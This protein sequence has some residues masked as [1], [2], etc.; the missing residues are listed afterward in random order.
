MRLFVA[1]LVA[2]VTCEYLFG[3]S[4]AFSST[5][6]IQNRALPNHNHLNEYVL[7]RRRLL[8]FV[9][10]PSIPHQDGNRRRNS[11]APGSY[12]PQ[13][14]ALRSLP[15]PTPLEVSKNSYILT[16]IILVRALAFVYGVAFLVA[17][18]Q[19]KGLIGDN[20]ICPARTILDNAQQRGEQIRRR[21]EAWLSSDFADKPPINDEVNSPKNIWIQFK[22]VSPIRKFG[23]EL[24]R[25]SR[26]QYWRER[27]WDRQDNMGRPVTTLLW[28]AKDRSKLNRWLDG[29]AMT[30]LGLS[31]LSFVFGA[32]N[33]PLMA[34]LWICQRSLMAV[35]GPFYGYGW[36]PQLAELGFHMMFLVPL[37]SVKQISLA[38][39]PPSHLV[40]YA[41]RFYLFKIMIGA[42]LIKL[43]SRD[44]KWKW[45]HLTAMNYFYE[46]QPIPNPFTRY[47]HFNP[48]LFHKFEVL[49]NHFVELIA[50]WLLLVPICKWRRLGGFIQIAFQGILITSGNLSFL[51]WLT[52]VPAIACL[53]DA[54]LSKLF[55][56]KWQNIAVRAAAG[57]TPRNSGSSI[58]RNIVSFGFV[59]LMG[60][61][62]IP[63][64][65]NLLSQKQ[66]MNASFDPLRLANTFGAFGDV[67]EVREEFIISATSDIDKPW[68]EYRFKV[69]PGEIMRRPKF[70]SPYHYRLDWQMWIAATMKD[71]NRSPWIYNFL[72]KLLQEDPEVLGLLD[73]N[74]FE[75]ESEERPKY[76]RIDKYRYKFCKPR[77]TCGSY[78]QY[79][80]R[81]F[82]ARVL[83]K[84]GVIGAEDLRPCI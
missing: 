1:T 49:I 7:G 76:V 11:F 19:N 43:R 84:Q 13:D 55:P 64:I 53:D 10:V 73:S 36:E 25:N 71:I 52:A 69:K 29:I 54:F 23:M 18:H 62:N 47:F 34:S 38:T 56:G 58:S 20:G 68:K 41:I 65:K 74:P 80:T 57:E 3:V 60:I 50:P 61:L 37:W 27:L 2:F 14:L 32:A 42:G 8:N 45:P 15:S 63:V 51:N 35:G 40:L 46:T 6:T 9:E 12:R 28:L 26:Y 77:K 4:Y 21:R 79:W 44:F 17:K 82:V 70:I 67:N 16:R 39:S 5:T 24:N 66:V 72:S 59:M 22:N 83:P 31:T 75:D 81:E 48:T 33:V 78:K 30:G